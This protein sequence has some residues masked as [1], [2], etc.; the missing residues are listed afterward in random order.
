M[1]NADRN[2]DQSIATDTPPESASHERPP[3]NIW[4]DLKDATRYLI[5]NPEANHIVM[6][7]I[8][9]AESL[10][11]KYISRNVPYTEIDYKAYME[12]VEMINNDERNYSMIRGGTGPLVYP[13]GHVY[14]YKIMDRITLGMN[15]L[16]AGQT[17]FRYLY[18]LT[19]A[20]QMV[21]YVLLELP[22]WCVVLACL[23]KRLHS[24]YVLRL[25]NDCFTT[26]FMVLTVL[27]FLIGAR[28]KKRIACLFASFTYTVAVSIKMNALLYLPGVLICIFQLTQGHMFETFSCI[29]VMVGW[30]I[31]VAREFLA[32]YYAEYLSTAFN[33]GRKFLYEWTINWQIIDEDVFQDKRFHYT[34]LASHAVVL[35][36]FVFVRFFPKRN[37][38]KLGLNT[39]LHPFQRVSNERA[40]VA[41]LGFILVV[42]N[43]IGIL[44]SRSLHYQFLSWYHWTLPIL[45]HYSSLPI[46]LG[47]PWYAAHEYCW[48]S[49]PPNSFASGLLQLLNHG[50]LL[51][52]YLNGH[53][54]STSSIL[55]QK[56]KKNQ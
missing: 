49:Y 26:F 44:F 18:I 1:N 33:F 16:S 50:M 40:T 48:N 24:I 31:F 21:I 4:Q 10:A 20:L 14:L 2:D 56:L 30:Q 39:L 28:F 3:I 34:L 36:V 25:F 45:L 54:P 12:Q 5:F 6:P 17:T 37:V 22:P 23:S 9:I 8:M 7:M 32:Q 42:T 13:A 53:T 35:C 43:F 27:I 52:V 15:N 47:V 29:C 46:Y 19:M 55:D 38:F 51:L 41:D 11:L